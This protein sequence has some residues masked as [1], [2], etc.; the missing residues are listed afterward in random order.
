MSAQATL[1]GLTATSTA[2]HAVLE[3]DLHGEVALAI[4]AYLTWAQFHGGATALLGGTVDRWLCAGRPVD[5]Q[6]S[7]SLVKLRSMLARFI[8][9]GGAVPSWFPPKLLEAIGEPWC[10]HD[11]ATN[12]QDL[13][14][15]GNSAG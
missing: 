1:P 14:A 15:A 4:M 6:I 10:S 2:S 5:P 11:L 7:R 8:G 3:Q 12:S 9:N 13:I